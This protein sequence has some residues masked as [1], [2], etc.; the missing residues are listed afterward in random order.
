MLKIQPSILAALLLALAGPEQDSRLIPQQPQA[1][2]LWA[3]AEQCV[4]RPGKPVSFLIQSPVSGPVAYTIAE[5]S[6]VSPLAKGTVEL[7]AGRPS[8][9]SATLDHAGFLLFE[10]R[11][12][13]SVAL[14]AVAVDPDSIASL[15]EEPKDFDDFWKRELSALKAVPLNARAAPGKPQKIALDGV[16]GRRIHGWVVLPE[17][18]GPFPAILEFPPYGSGALACPSPMA[19]AIYALVSVHDSDPE[20]PAKNPYQPERADDHQR[21]YFKYA[22][23]AGVRMIDYLISLPQ[24]DAK[25]IAVTGKSQGGGLAIMVAGLDGRVSHLSAVVPAFGQHAGTRLGRSSGF[26]WW[27]WQKDKDGQRKSGDLLL[28]ET[29]YFETAH[30]ARRFRGSAR[31]FAA[32]IDTVCPPS[33]VVAVFNGFPGPK[34]LVHGPIQ[35]HDWN[36]AGENWWPLWNSGLKQWAG[37]R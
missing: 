19:G 26:P 14:A 20:T 36:Q 35:D 33:S 37:V 3:G 1:G 17:G 8:K 29:A 27:V 9:I 31:V 30:F 6:R 15:G 7:Q 5:D 10:A 34:E 18:P 11:Q 12:D 21:N 2:R 23:L 24:T 13:K 25:R 28:R 16:E 22:A 32:W 4:V